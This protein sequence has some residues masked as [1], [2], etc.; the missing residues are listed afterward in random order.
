MKV[1]TSGLI[2]PLKNLT[3]RKPKIFGNWLKGDYLMTM[4]AF[5]YSKD[6]L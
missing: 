6:Q 1:V 2:S 5:E 4:Q 3:G